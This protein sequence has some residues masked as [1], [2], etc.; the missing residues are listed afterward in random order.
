LTND[1]PN[2]VAG[3][4]DQMAWA[5]AYIW[6]TVLASPVAVSDARL[7]TTFHHIHN[8]Q[9]LFWQAWNHEPFAFRDATDFPTAPDLAEWARDAHLK[10]RTFLAGLE[11][12]ALEREFREPWTDQFEARFPRPAPPHT[13]AESVVQ[14]VLHTAHHRGQACTRLRELGCQPPTVDFIVWLW[15][16]KPAPDWACLDIASGVAESQQT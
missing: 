11:P 12:A 9:H 5:D 1:L 16:G 8:V 13:L 15:A 3:L 4:V 7:L 14:V 10:V 6:T 2:H